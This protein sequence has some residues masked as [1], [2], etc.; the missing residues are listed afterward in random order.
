MQHI[1]RSSGSGAFALLSVAI[2]L[3]ACNE[4]AQEEPPFDAEFE[5]AWTDVSPG[6]PPLVTT[7]P[8][9]LEDGWATSTPL[10]EG[11]DT[12]LLLG[13]LEAI[14]GGEYPGVDG[15][16]VIRNDRVIAEGYFNGFGRE[17]VHNVRSASKSI[18]SALVGIA[19]DQ[20]HLALEDLISQYIPE[21]ESYANM[22]DLKRSIRVL[23]LLTMQSGIDC[24][25]MDPSARGNE[26][27]MY[28]TRDW[29][30]Y[31]LDLP[32]AGPPG[33]L[34]RYCSGGVD[35]LGNIVATATGVPLD[36]FAAASLFAP[37][38][39][40]EL[41][42]AGGGG[43]RL[44]PRDSA[45]IGGLF[46]RQGL[47]NGVRVLTDTWVQASLQNVTSIN[48]TPYGYLWWKNIFPMADGAL[49]GFSAIGNGG[50]LIFVVPTAQLVVVFSGSNYNHRE[51]SPPFSIVE[52]WILP[53][54]R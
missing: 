22:D 16:V 14:R 29:T 3:S 11:M 45:K 44:R 33:T 41:T 34:G 2:G 49:E 12:Q 23:D 8:E 4:D 13:G 21:F 10:A 36:D 32:M 50:N 26:E 42:A 20:G 15:L 43:M 31:M 38:G 47:W 53:A 39:I 46:L 51:V 37:L 6:L 35:L 19:V 27:A 18:T 1:A 24:D 30:Q 40:Y 7:A 5:A 52:R 25:D 17:S 48:M 28:Q 9:T 54:L